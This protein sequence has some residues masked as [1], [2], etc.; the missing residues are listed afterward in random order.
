MNFKTDEIPT[1][2]EKLSIK[3]APEDKEKEGKQLLKVVM[4]TFL[5]AADALLEMLILH[6]PSP[7]TAQ[8]Y[9]AETLYEGPPDDEACI[10]I[11]DCDPKAPLMLYVSK[12]VPTSDKGRFYA[13]GRV[14]AGTVKSGLKVRIQGPNYTPGKKDDLFIKAIQRTVLMMGGKV[15][16]IENVPAGNILGLVGIDQFLLKSGTLTTSDTAHN[17]KVMKFS[18]SPVVQR[19]VEV[20][21][22]QDLPKLVE[23]LK[24]LSKSD[25]CVLTSISPSGEHI[26]AGAGELHL[27]ICLK[28]LE[29][30]HAGVPLRIS[31]PVVSYRETVTAKSS[32][33]ALSKSPNKHNRLYMIAEP[34]DPEVS[35]EI[36]AGRIGPRDDFK[37]RARILADDFGWDVT[38]ARKIWCF[39]PDTNGANL[40]VDQTKAVQYLSEIKDSVVSGFQW[41]SREGPVAEEPM[42]SCR[43]NI[44]DVTLHA[45][46]IHRGGGQLIPTARRVL[47]AAAL[48]AEPG[49]LEPVFLVEIQVPEGAM[50]GVYGVLTRRRGHVFNEEQR[51][52][53]PLFTIKAYLPVMESFGFNADLRSHTSGQA[54][55]TLVF[56]HW[57]ILPGGS[58][59]DGTSKVGQV[60]QAM[61][62]R[63]GIKEVVPGVENVSLLSFLNITLEDLLTMIYSTMISYRCVL[64]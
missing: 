21:N 63:K 37:A 22:A 4:R 25:P 47:Y 53:T 41:A 61:R 31:D 50:G 9:R 12:M 36:E 58:P 16:P 23:G 26:V 19:S 39:G 13:F 30:D 17:L 44:M 52:G 55:P 46:A 49:L 15:D 35:K 27:E 62:K 34:L 51:P 5:P 8:K 6:L 32:I 60:V 24:R 29:E 18:V 33:T 64:S 48:L 7:V 28:D 40:L 57:Q 1:L 42:R 3:L 14:F 59:I 11:R 43:F 10:G 20:K 56:D 45:D 38:D 54:F 2:L